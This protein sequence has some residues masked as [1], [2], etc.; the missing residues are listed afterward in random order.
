[1]SHLKKQNC[2]SALIN[3][4][5]IEKHQKSRRYFLLTP[6]VALLAFSGA[7]VRAQSNF[8]P[9]FLS[10]DP[11]AVADLS[12]FEKGQIVPPGTYRV[13]IYLN[14]NYVTTRDVMFNASQNGPE[15]EACLSS[16]QLSAMGVDTVG[17][18]GIAVLKEG[19]CVPLAQTIKAAT[20]T[21][22]FDRQRLN[23]SVPQAFMRGSVRGYIPPEQWDNGIT[24]GLLNYN[25][26]G[27]N[28]WGQSHSDNY[29]LNLQSGFNLGAW[30]LRDNTTW[31]YN[32]GSNSSSSRNSWQHI[33]TYVERNIV[34]LRARLVVGDGYTPSDVFDGVNFRGAQISSDDNML[35]DSQRGFA[36]VVRGIARTTARVSVRQNGYD[37]YQSTVPPG[38][39]VINDLYPSGL[40]GDL[41]VTIKEA[42]GSSQVFTVPYSSVPVLQREGR[43][44]FAVT[45]GQFRSG[46]QQQDKPKFAQATALWGLP[47][48]FTVYGGTQLADNYRAFTGGLGKN[49]GILG[50]VSADI[51]QANTTLP[52]E[53]RHQG[54]SMR[55]LYNKSLAEVGTNFQLVG[56]RYSTQGFYTLSDASYKQMSGYSVL[57]QDGA[58]NVTPK[59]TDYYNLY[60]TK[61]GRLQ[62][63]ISQQIGAISSL[64]LSGSR[65]TYWNSG[66]TD[67][68][69]QVGYSMTFNDISY[70]LSYSLTQGMGQEN[71]DQ[72][73]ALNVSIPI[74]HWL[75]PDSR[76]ALRHSN[77]NY[78][79]SNDLK[80]RSTNTVGMSGTLLK[81]NNLGYSVQQGYNNQDSGYVSNAGLNYQGTYATSNLGY[82]RNDGYNQAYYGV[83]GG[84]I[85]HSDGI[86]FSQPLG[87]TSVLV[88]APGA[89]GVSVE[90]ATGVRTDWRGY[91]VVPYASEYRENRVALDPNSLAANVDLDEPV[92]NVV[93]TRGAIVRANFVTRVGMKALV[94]LM[95]QGK[96]VPFGATVTHNE[97]DSG[98]IVGDAGQAY[99]TGLPLRGELKAKWGE[100]ANEQCVASYQLPEANQQQ[101][102]SYAN[103]VCR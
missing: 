97:G 20:S 72:L 102:L 52:D 6:L 66:E 77:I 99:L 89:A 10:D 30:R 81:D 17:I 19:A 45:A 3:S 91:A 14:D 33:N 24:A 84:V 22:D 39:F 25:F 65:Q 79:N 50:A 74:S 98:S 63:N 83:S 58:I 68:Q 29:Y 15:L 12:R 49:L 76:S 103:V 80:G 34:P 44:K 90:N 64:Y 28:G 46:G 71:K 18:P 43:V 21:Y 16:K 60:H 62:V 87:D 5:R 47:A 57:T 101:A 59:L 75:S 67:D 51:T 41:Q 54:Q 93:P 88:K 94:T 27:S 9:Y 13:D 26:T 56:Y 100:S 95:H 86:T 8:N 4:E 61:R 73:L 48:G 2:F 1:M 11:S 32:S 82:S 96:T 23:I 37:I 42:D 38:P 40:S 70:N 69:L 92:E 53:S 35:S 78:S 36:P 55:F 85:A 31:S 7:D